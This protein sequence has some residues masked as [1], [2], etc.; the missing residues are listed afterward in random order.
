MSI[1]EAVKRSLSAQIA[2]KLALLLLALMVI[3]AVAITTI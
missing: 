3:A 2:L 1:V